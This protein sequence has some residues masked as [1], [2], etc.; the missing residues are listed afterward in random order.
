MKNAS[1]AA[2]AIIAP[3]YLSQKALELMRSVAGFVAEW[4]APAACCKTKYTK[5]KSGL[6]M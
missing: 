2:N 6:I 5:G 1:T 4:N 3:K